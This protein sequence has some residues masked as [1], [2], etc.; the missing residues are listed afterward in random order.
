MRIGIDL[1]GT[2]IEA[3][4]L[5]SDGTALLRHRVPTPAGDYPAIVQ[6]V[7]D[8]VGYIEAESGRKGVQPARTLRTRLNAEAGESPTGVTH[9]PVG[10]MTEGERPRRRSHSHLPNGG[11]TEVGQRG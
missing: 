4:A 8:R 7:A 6:R 3:I 11:S 10:A 2:K 1:G 9:E 5:G